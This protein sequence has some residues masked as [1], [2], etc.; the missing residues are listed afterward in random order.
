MT[1]DVKPELAAALEALAA[2]QG[3][4]VEAYLQ[5]LVERESIS[6]ASGT[7]NGSSGMVWEDGLFVYRTGKALSPRILDEAI[8]RARDAR[9]RHVL[10]DHS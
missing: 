3:L 9:S 10:G 4:S 1:I 7:Q 5:M 2:E 6:E 8:R